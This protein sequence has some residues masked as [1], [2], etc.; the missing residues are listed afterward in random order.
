MKAHRDLAHFQDYGDVA[1]LLSFVRQTSR[2]P[3]P[4]V[5]SI[6][7]LAPVFTALSHGERPNYQSL[8]VGALRERKTE[9]SA[10]IRWMAGSKKANMKTRA[11][12]LMGV[13]GWD[14]YRPD[15]EASLGS[16]KEW[17][18]QTAIAALEEVLSPWAADLLRAAT[19]HPDPQTRKRASEA[20]R[21]FPQ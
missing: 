5:E 6:E 8:D 4:Y 18:R 21:R 15:L 14:E 12:E 10:I 9:V 11:L 7:T 16:D 2:N 13:L 20:L 3:Q 19:N 1:S 17:I